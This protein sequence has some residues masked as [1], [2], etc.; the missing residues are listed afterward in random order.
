M[1]TTNIGKPFGI[2]TSKNQATAITESKQT[3]NAG[4]FYITKTD[5]S[6]TGGVSNTEG[7]ASDAIA[8]TINGNVLR[9][10]S[11][12]DA[13]KLANLNIGSGT[14]TEGAF[15]YKG[16]VI[17]FVALPTDAKVGDVYIVND[18]FTID[19]ITYPAYSS[20][21]NVGPSEWKPLG[22]A[23]QIGTS[24]EPSVYQ[25]TYSTQ[26]LYYKTYN[27]TSI[28]SFGITV[29]NFTGLYIQDDSSIGIKLKTADVYLTN[30]NKGLNFHVSSNPIN[31]FNIYCG[32]GIKTDDIDDGLGYKPGLI[33]N[34]ATNISY[35]TT[36]SDYYKELR[37]SGLNINKDGQL[38]IALATNFNPIDYI[39][40]GLVIVG[41]SE[42]NCAGLAISGNAL[43][44]WLN[45]SDS[46]SNTINSLVGTS[47]NE[48]LKLGDGLQKDSE[49]RISVLMN[50]DTIEVNAGSEL[51]VRY[52]NT[53]TA[54]FNSGLSINL[55]ST[56]H[57]SELNDLPVSTC[58]IL[59]NDP[60][61][62]GVC[63]DIPALKRLVEL[64]MA[65]K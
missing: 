55:P 22:G 62:N 64:I 12:D 26:Q 50:N 6:N 57:V 54:N 65:A 7:N 25:S 35:E 32:D 42:T 52:N 30:D 38:S 43:V 51:Q 8:L 15:N 17:Q 16:N 40:N 49:D 31:E 10:I 56:D 21:V 37:C 18:V 61:G 9:G 3:N 2:V 46:F 23:M 20:V 29:D 53:L 14:T 47:I 5:N 41:T 39:G 33:L 19:N 13:T 44:N 1:A 28:S 59:V 24:V 34:I 27:N 11:K 63:V 60:N 58:A 45:T 4:Q 36:V 48:N